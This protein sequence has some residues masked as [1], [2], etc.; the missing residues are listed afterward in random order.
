[1]Q[2]SKIPFNISILRLTPDRL[3]GLKP[4]KVLDIF[5]GATGR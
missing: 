2:R 4:V 5:D 1:M 3:V